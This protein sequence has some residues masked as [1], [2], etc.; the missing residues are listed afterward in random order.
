[1]R[2]LKTAVHPDILTLDQSTFVRNAARAIVLKGEMILMLY[3]ARYHDYT[4]PGGGVDENE[5]LLE[6]LIRELQEETGAQNIRDIE[7]FG[8]YEEF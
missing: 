1:M 8:L 3:T 5:N 2:L 4:L 6:G 7:D